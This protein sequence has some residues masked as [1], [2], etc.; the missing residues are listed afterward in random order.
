MNRI[1][2]KFI[3]PIISLPLCLSSCATIVSDKT[4]PISINSTPPG[5][6]VE[7]VDKR[8][9]TKFT[10]TTPVTAVLESGDGYFS[11]GKYSVKVSSPGYSEYS[12]QIRASNNGWYWGNLLFGGLIGFLIVDPLTGAMY[13]IDEKVVSASL[14]PQNFQPLAAIQ[15]APVVQAPAP[16]ANVE[17]SNTELV[18]KLSDLK[19]LR[20]DKIITESEYQRKRK[21][22]VDNF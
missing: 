22:I 20:D 13:E 4:F 18:K 19:S 14:V 15:A 3:T 8:G 16:Q 9:V 2:S 5:A 17:K 7:V 12:S 6:K 21:E 1:L 11:R 10:G